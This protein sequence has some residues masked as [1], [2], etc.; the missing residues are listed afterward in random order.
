MVN[1]Y[2]NAF[3]A[4]QVALILYLLTIPCLL[5]ESFTITFKHGDKKGGCDKNMG[6]G[7][8]RG[9]NSDAFFH[10]LQIRIDLDFQYDIIKMKKEIKFKRAGFFFKKTKENII[11][12]YRQRVGLVLWGGARAGKVRVLR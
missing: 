8:M 10:F 12:M 3:E 7:G 11:T 4:W 5:G 9:R 2:K 1:R 6:M